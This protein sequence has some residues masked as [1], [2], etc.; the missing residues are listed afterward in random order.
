V[1][2]EGTVERGV[3]ALD[4]FHFRPMYAGANMGHSSKTPDLSVRDR[5]ERNWL[6]GRGVFRVGQENGKDGAVP[7]SS[8]F[9]LDLYRASMAFGDFFTDP[10]S[11]SSAHVFFGREEGLKD[12]FEIFRSD[13]RAVIFD[14]ESNGLTGCKL[15]ERRVDLQHSTDGDSIDG[16]GH[17]VRYQLL[18][19]SC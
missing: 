17:N 13:S 15:H 9:G 19:L 7:S 18:D 4:G 2:G 12:S 6:T 1:L 11:E 8:I 16:I 10:Q 3:K 5:A 14:L